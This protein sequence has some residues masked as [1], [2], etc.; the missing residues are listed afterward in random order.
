VV[1]RIFTHLDSQLTLS[2]NTNPDPETRS[3][4]V[5][6]AKKYKVPIRCVWFKTP[7]HICEHNDAVRSM[8]ARLNPEKREGLPKIAFNGFTSR[9]QEPTLKEGFH[10]ILPVEFQFRGTKEEYEL[11][12]KYWV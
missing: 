1:S 8:N 3:I 5:D 10:D 12:G 6:L 4:W 9:F 11:W 2:D 7:I